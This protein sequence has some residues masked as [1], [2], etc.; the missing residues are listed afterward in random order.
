MDTITVD[1]WHSN[2]LQENRNQGLEK[3]IL[4]TFLLLPT[5]VQCWQNTF[6]EHNFAFYNF[7]TL[8]GGMGVL[9]LIL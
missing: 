8:K 1:N 6:I 7:P 2:I 5:P 9:T 4:Y 3:F